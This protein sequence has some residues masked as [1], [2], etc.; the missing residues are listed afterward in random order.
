M[1]DERRKITPLEEGT[2]RKGGRNPP[3]TS[4][5]RPPPPKGSGGKAVEDLRAERDEALAVL[6][7]L[8]A[9]RDDHATELLRGTVAFNAARAL[10]ACRTPK[11]PL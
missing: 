1:S 9:C 4:D 5:K 6:R 3:N 7:E 11:V 8:V 2:Y 10:L